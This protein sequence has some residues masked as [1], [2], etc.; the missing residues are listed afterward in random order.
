MHL[1]NHGDHG[2]EDHDHGDMVHTA[3]SRREVIVFS[4]SAKPDEVKSSIGTLLQ[5]IEAFLKASGCKLIGHIKGMIEG[6]K[7]CFLAFSI[8]SF[9][10]NIR[11]KGE[12]RGDIGEMVLILNIIVYGVDQAL[13]DR[14]V[15]QLIKARFAVKHQEES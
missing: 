10:E 6:E 14:E 1:H 12:L 9:G 13:I 3:Y 15:S 4:D 7:Q 11:Y 5:D 8:T 2:H